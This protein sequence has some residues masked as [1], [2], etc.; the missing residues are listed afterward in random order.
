MLLSHWN[1]QVEFSWNNGMLAVNTYNSHLS[2]ATC[3]CVFLLPDPSVGCSSVNAAT[4]SA[5]SCGLPRI[6]R[7]EMERCSVI[8]MG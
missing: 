2:P 1:F 6:K 3:S 4:I 7:E 5:K 8:S